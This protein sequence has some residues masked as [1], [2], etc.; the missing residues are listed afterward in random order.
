MAKGHKQVARRSLTPEE[1]LRLRFKEVARWEEIASV[2]AGGWAVR[3]ARVDGPGCCRPLGRWRPIRDGHLWGSPDGTFLFRAAVSVPREFKGQPVL[4][5]LSTPTEMLVRIDGKLAN[6]IDPNRSEVPLLA[7]A[8]GGERFAIELEAYVRSAPDDMR[9]V[10]QVSWGCTQVWRDPRLVCPDRVVQRFLYDFGTAL[11]VALCPQVDEDVREFLLFHLDETLKH[12]DRDTEDR[13]A[14]HRGLARA[15]DYLRRHVYEAEGLAGQGALALVGH[16][17]VDVAYHWRI[18]QGIRKNARTTVVQLA[19]MDEYPEFLYCHTQPYVYEMLKE[20]Y[21]DL[22]ERVKAKVRT[23]QWEL[24][25]ATYVEP[26]CNV[27]SGESLIR[28]CLY[29]KLFYLREFGVDV[30]TVWLPDV[31]GNSWVMPQILARAGVRYFVSNKMS[32]WNDTNEFPHTNFIW[33]GVDGSEIFACVPASHFISWLAPD[34]LLA[35]WAGF[36]EK[37][38]VGES[39]NMYGFGDGG[40]GATR[41]M[42]E[43]A[44]RIRQFPGLPRTR[45]VTGKGYLD[46]AFRSPEK[47]ETWDDELYLEMHRG[48]TTTKARLKQLNRRCELT[49]RDAEL[50][51]VLAE[52]YG[53][54]IP[55]A[56]LAAAWKQILVNQFHDILPGSHT[57]PVG[58][59]A[60]ETYAE[61][62]RDL[63]EAM[64]GAAD[65]IA[66][67]V[68]TDAAESDWVN[69]VVFNSLSW[70][71][72]GM[73][74]ALAEA[75][76]CRLVDAEGRDIPCQVREDDQ[77]LWV[78]FVARDVP[79]CGYATY[80]LGRS[81][82]NGGVGAGPCA[83][84]AMAAPIA[85]ARGR[86]GDLPLQE[87]AKA[88]LKVSPRALENR[89]F[90]IR[91]NRSGEITSLLDKRCGR[92]VV[93]RGQRANALQLFEDK[94]GN[95]DAW[96]IVRMYRDKQWKLPP[97]TSSEV[98]ESGPVR[99]GI[100][101]VRRFFE[102]TLE[103]TIW[104]HSDIARVDFETRVDW[105]ER[106]KLLKVAFPANVLARRATFDLSYGSITRPTHR[107]TS[108]DKAKF[109]VCGHQWADL[110]EAGYGVSVLNDCKYGWDVEGNVIRLSLLRGSIRPDPDSDLGEHTFTYSLFPH[111]GTWQEAGT[112]RAA[113]E[114]NCPF[115]VAQGLPSGFAEAL[116]PRHSFLSVDAPNV[117]VGALKPAEDGDGC[118]LRLVEQHG[119]RGGVAVRFDRELRS[120][121]ECDLLERTEERLAHDGHELR[122]EMRPFEI[123]SFRVRFR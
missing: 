108:W 61:A 23:G 121:E 4:F 15:T 36:K 1:W 103:Q 55:R 14:Y 30:D 83:R 38:E 5:E 97:A 68:S 110:S 117:H 101:V 122:T 113:Y 104:I 87:P 90:R 65:Q 22:F 118:I 57:S 116:P 91:L 109:E 107:N 41:E 59:E 73:V 92:E 45:L 31:F 51:N 54:E 46:Q 21:P 106:N 40:G 75:G 63:S 69:V 35:N 86:H 52:P 81:P 119:G 28:Q 6:G 25:G 102:S 11:D 27:P 72:T 34:Q 114:L 48:V 120:V 16:S 64:A 112:V 111:Q 20:H 60:E 76:Q 26:D 93:A 79:A 105:R 19:L 95:Y 85:H 50:W 17:H 24:V 37:V 82:S 33:R 94:P 42:L 53:R 43:T 78:D 3:E 99:A 67:N 39:M 80:F 32:T 58:Q 7:R 66:V 84:P 2:A 10:G 123:K 8:R 44:R 13:T 47:L 88:K 74:S 77:G 12:L 98:V 18:R 56:R 29:G 9:V 115:Y 62:H 89:F 49:A 96:D 71:A 100:R 70:P